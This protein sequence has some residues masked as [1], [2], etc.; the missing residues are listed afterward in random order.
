MQIVF[1]YSIIDVLLQCFGSCTSPEQGFLHSGLSKISCPVIE[2][3][4]MRNLKF[5]IHRPPSF[6]NH[7]VLE[8]SGSWYSLQRH[9]GCPEEDTEVCHCMCGAV[10]LEMRATELRNYYRSRE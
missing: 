6:D 5:D 4:P 7:V 8:K 9:D 1:R 10:A 2:K 3:L